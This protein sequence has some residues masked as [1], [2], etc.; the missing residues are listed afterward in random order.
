MGE[1]IGAA[2]SGGVRG[3]YHKKNGAAKAA[4]SDL[5]FILSP[6]M[7]TKPRGAFR[8]QLRSLRPL[9]YRRLENRIVPAAALILFK[10][11]R[12]DVIAVARKARIRE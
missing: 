3:S 10:P 4:G 11:R 1:H 2:D 7:D 6:L 8:Q 9:S 12:L 5:F